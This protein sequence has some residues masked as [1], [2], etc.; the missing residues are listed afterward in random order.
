MCANI[1][2]KI[3]K[4]QSDVYFI[5]IFNNEA[6][7]KCSRKLFDTLPSRIFRIHTEL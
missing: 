6:L 5:A 3:Q 2:N 4:T 7:K 1:M